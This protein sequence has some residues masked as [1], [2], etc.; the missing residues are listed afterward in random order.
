LAHRTAAEIAC[1]RCPA[2][3]GWVTVW[4]TFFA[5]VLMIRE[6]TDPDICLFGATTVLLLCRITTPAQA[7]AGGWPRHLAASGRAASSTASA[8]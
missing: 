3:N 2:E 7:F 4:V 8:R 5:M 1:R 6:A